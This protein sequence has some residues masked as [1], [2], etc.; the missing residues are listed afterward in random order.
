MCARDI[1]A[2]QKTLNFVPATLSLKSSLSNRFFFPGHCLFNS[3]KVNFRILTNK[4]TEL[5]RISLKSYDYMY[6]S[7]LTEVLCFTRKTDTGRKKNN[8]QASL[9]PTLQISLRSSTEANFSLKI[10]LSNNNQ[11]IF[12]TTLLKISWNINTF[13]L[14]ELF[15][16]IINYKYKLSMY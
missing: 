3:C 11:Y 12:V 14:V 9:P 13:M 5:H 2:I 7:L 6:N 8:P 4:Y 10:R 1:T 15:F 16:L